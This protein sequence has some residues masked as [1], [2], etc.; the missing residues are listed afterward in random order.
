MDKVG[1][2][3]KLIAY[4]SFRN[5]KAEAHGDRAPLRLIRPRTILYAGAFALVATVML[6]GLTHK[7]VLDVNVVPD[8]N[9]LFVQVSGG[10]IRNGYTVRILNK[11]R[12]AH[13]FEIAVTGLKEPS[14]PMSASTPA[15]PARGQIRRC[16]RA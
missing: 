14:L 4:D 1:R 11:K 3:R 16:P 6:F 9:P 8:R 10:G 2:P 7:T 13:K 5:L 12:G 15:S